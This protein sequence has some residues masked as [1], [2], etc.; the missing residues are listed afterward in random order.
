MNNGIKSVLYTLVLSSVVF[1]NANLLAKGMDDVPALLTDNNAREAI[2]IIRN[3]LQSEPT[4][5][6]AHSTLSEIYYNSHD[7]IKAEKEL[8][9]LK[10]M[11]AGPE[12]WLIPL[13]RLYEMNNDSSKILALFDGKDIKNDSAWDRDVN[14]IRAQALLSKNDTPQA[15]QYLDAI[16]KADQNHVEALWVLSK[17]QIL[18][19][20]LKL[21]RRCL[22]HL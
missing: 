3:H 7:F 11:N 20:D 12:Y 18:S 14:V 22:K 1:A 10:A 2:V 5:F 6:K 15:Q 16:L 21:K 4:D 17:I 19:N 8:L 13:A 9:Q